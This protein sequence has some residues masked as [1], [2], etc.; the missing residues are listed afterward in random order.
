MKCENCKETLDAC[1]NCLSELEKNLT[2]ICYGTSE[3]E[4]YC[5][6]ECFAG[7]QEYLVESRVIEEREKG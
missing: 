2:I 3:P 7:S 5:D 4:H 1:N 6:Y